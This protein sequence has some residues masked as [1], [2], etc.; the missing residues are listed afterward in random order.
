MN[1][2]E[3]SEGRKEKVYKERTREGGRVK[4]GRKKVRKE[5]GV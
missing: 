1:E 5:E 2:R 4:D 3:K